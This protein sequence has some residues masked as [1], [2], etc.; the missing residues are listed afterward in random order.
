[1]VLAE[2]NLTKEQGTVVQR[3][4]DRIVRERFGGRGRAVLTNPINI[5]IGTRWRPR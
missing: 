4:L 3:A 1:V 5:G 2:L